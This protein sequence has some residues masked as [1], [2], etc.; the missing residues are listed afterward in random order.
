MKLRGL[1]II[2]NRS[3]S[4]TTTQMLSSNGNGINRWWSVF[5]APLRERFGW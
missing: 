5:I 3:E 2:Q 1:M 4:L